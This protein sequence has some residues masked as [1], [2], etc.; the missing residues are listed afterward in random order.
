MGDAVFYS[1]VYGYRP[2]F[3]RLDYPKPDLRFFVAWIDTNSSGWLPDERS[4]AP[5]ILV[6]TPEFTLNV[7]PAVVVFGAKGDQ[8]IHRLREDDYQRI[9]KALLN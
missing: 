8:H 3:L 2:P 4:Y 1:A 9:V 6:R 7:L 5:G